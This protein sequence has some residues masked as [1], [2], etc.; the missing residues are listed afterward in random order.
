[1]LALGKR[2][3]EGLEQLLLPAADCGLLVVEEAD[4]FFENGGVVEIVGG[5]GEVGGNEV[6][7]LEKQFFS[8]FYYLD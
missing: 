8:L 4:V 6:E 5:G 1:M 7:Q 2:V 3:D